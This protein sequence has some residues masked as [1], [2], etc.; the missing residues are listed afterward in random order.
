MATATKT[1]QLQKNAYWHEMDETRQKKGPDGKPLDL[2]SQPP[3]TYPIG[4]LL[5]LTPEQV[6]KFGKGTL[7]PLTPGT[8]RKVRESHRQQQIELARA[9][10][11]AAEQDLVA[12]EAVKEQKVLELDASLESLR[13]QVERCKLGLMDLGIDVDQE[14]E[15]EKRPKGKASDKS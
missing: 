13:V 11:W 8:A 5:D 12:A 9:T 4:H 15:Q 3:R 2:E 10:L 1:Y 14:R 7:A 6:E